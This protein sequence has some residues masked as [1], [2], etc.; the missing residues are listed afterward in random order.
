MGIVWR[1]EGNFR[2]S[3]YWFSRA[4]SLGDEESNLEIGK[5]YLHNERDPRKAIIYFKRVTPSGWVS[6]A[7]LEEAAELRR[8][9][10]K[11]LRTRGQ[12]VSR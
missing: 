9:A 2:R 5:H 3:L 1:N 11:L 12:R 6:E 8:E 7:G 4:V 10:T